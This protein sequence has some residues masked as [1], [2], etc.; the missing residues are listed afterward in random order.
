MDTHL[1]CVACLGLQHARAVLDTP[2]SCE[3]CS[4]FTLKS[5]HR[6]LSRKAS[7]G[8][9]DPLLASAAAPTEYDEPAI[10]STSWDTPLPVGFDDCMPA[11]HFDS[12]LGDDESGNS[13]VSVDILLSEGEDDD[14]PS[15]PHSPE[16]WTCIK[17]AGGRLRSWISHGPRC[18]RRLLYPAMKGKGCQKP[19]GQLG[20]FYPYSLSAWRRLCAVGRIPF[21]LLTLSKG[22]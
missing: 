8:T 20:S 1:I 18:R 6:R 2:G 10:L 4:C 22:G 19:S 13:D 5:L 17:C 3:H 21:L 14:G 9:W 15:S 7:L 16:A 11:D 12:L